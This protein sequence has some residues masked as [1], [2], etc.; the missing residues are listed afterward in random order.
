VVGE[1]LSTGFAEV[2][3]RSGIPVRTTPGDVVEL[4]T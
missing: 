3:A 4:P 2:V 1:L